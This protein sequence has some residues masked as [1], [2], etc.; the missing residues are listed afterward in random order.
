MDRGVPPRGRSRL[1]NVAALVMA[2]S[3]VKIAD[4]SAE[5]CCSERSLHRKLVKLWKTL[6]APDR[7]EGLRKAAS[8]GLIV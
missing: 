4:M 8:E 2:A 3:G 6:G 7:D 5:L 1:C